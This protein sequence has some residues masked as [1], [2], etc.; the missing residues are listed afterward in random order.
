MTQNLT[1]LHKTGLCL[2]CAHAP[3]CVYLDRATRP[4]WRCEE[5]DDGGRDP[6]PS[7]FVVPSL[8][9]PEAPSLP[10]LCGNCDHLETCSL[11]KAEGGVW[12]CEEYS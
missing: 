9:P 12:Y 6:Q 10:G 3:S 4:V 1:R 8:D 2:T 11:P 7:L 5:F